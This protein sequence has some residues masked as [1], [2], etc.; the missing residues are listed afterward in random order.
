MTKVEIQELGNVIIQLVNGAYVSGATIN[1]SY[2]DAEILHATLHRLFGD[3]EEN[4]KAQ[5]DR[6]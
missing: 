2:K 5:N 3:K 4:E 1:A 6:S